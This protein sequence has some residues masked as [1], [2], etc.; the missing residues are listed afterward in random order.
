MTRANNASPRALQPRRPRL[1]LAIFGLLLLALIPD[2]RST[3]EVPRDFDV[4]PG[5]ARDTLKRFSAQARLEI[6]FPSENTLGVVTN[7]V[8]GRLSPEEAI[9]ALLAGT[10]LTAARDP[11]TGAYSVRP[12]SPAR[13]K[14]Q[15]QL[16]R[17]A[18]VSAQ[19]VAPGSG[20]SS[21]GN[22][23]VQLSPFE[24]KADAN[25]YL[26]A[27]T[28]TGTRYAAPI[29]ELPFSV[30]IVSSEFMEDFHLF[31]LSGMAAL[32]YTSSF[33][34][35]ASEVSTGSIVVRGI[36]GFSL[37]KNG[38]REGGVFGPASID[39]IEVIKGASASIYGQAEPSG[40]V[41]RITKEGDLGPSNPLRWMWARNNTPER[42]S[43]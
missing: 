11:K 16:A 8:R 3:P 40:M 19:G 41:N 31:D 13:D 17:S 2:L 36:R 34:N 26:A 29:K 28:T 25:G 23:P 27:E 10:N 38:I 35:E 30:N 33:A 42:C 39:R 22:V 7:P 14:A 9:T 6:V 21:A 15:A 24:V 37:Y 1:P 18:S 20:P 32:S 4:P 12:Q 5:Q 43:T